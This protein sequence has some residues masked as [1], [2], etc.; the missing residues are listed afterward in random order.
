V[1]DLA[2]AVVQVVTSGVDWPGVAAAISGGVVGLAGIIATVRQASRS[3]SAQNARAMLDEKRRTYTHYLSAIDAATGAHE[4]TW[5]ETYKSVVDAGFAVKMTAPVEVANLARALT[6]LFGN[7]ERGDEWLGQVGRAADRVS[8]A[9]RADLGVA[10]S[11]TTSDGRK[12]EAAK[13]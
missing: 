6:D 11:S 8:N 4:A 3:I 10:D 7:T 12:R 5:V 13:S 2:S 9:M 1:T